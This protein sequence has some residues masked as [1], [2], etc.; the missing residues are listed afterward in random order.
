MEAEIER[1]VK[2]ERVLGKGLRPGG[3]VIGPITIAC[4]WP[5]PVIE[6]TL[7]D[8]NGI[9]LDCDNALNLAYA[10]ATGRELPETLATFCLK[11]E[12]WEGR[13]QLAAVM[14]RVRAAVFDG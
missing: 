1:P 11:A 8:G 2:V 12:H 4:D 3:Q 10:V 9:W 14:S 6:I 5:E 7:P 13:G